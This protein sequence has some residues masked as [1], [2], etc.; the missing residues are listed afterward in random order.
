MALMRKTDSIWW[1]GFSGLSATV[2]SLG[3]QVVNVASTAVSVR[4]VWRKRKPVL[5]GKMAIAV[6]FRTGVTTGT[7][8]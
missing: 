5:Y 2:C 4:I 7:A 8:A 3:Q 6:Y 1:A